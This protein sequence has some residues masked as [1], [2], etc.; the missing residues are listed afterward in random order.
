METSVARLPGHAPCPPDARRRTGVVAPDP[1]R[2]RWSSDRFPSAHRFPSP[3][4]PLH[5]PP[6]DRLGGGGMAR[7][8]V[9][10]RGEATGRVRLERAGV[11][12]ESVEQ[13]P[14]S[15]IRLASGGAVVSALVTLVR[16]GV[17]E[18]RVGTHDTPEASRVARVVEAQ[19]GDRAGVGALPVYGLAAEDDA[20]LVGA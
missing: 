13:S 1:A 12:V 4:D 19:A 10:R 2:R 5:P 20:M 9:A 7:V 15:A 6:G 17:G 16:V 3:L 14:R 18:N 11:G 8:G